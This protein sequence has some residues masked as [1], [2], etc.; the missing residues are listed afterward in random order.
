[1][2]MFLKKTYEL[3]ALKASLRVEGRE[4]QLLLELESNEGGVPNIRSQWKVPARAVGVPQRLERREMPFFALPNAIVDG[5]QSELSQLEL[6]WMHPL[7]L[8]LVKPYGYLG[9]M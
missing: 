3:L 9:V 4:P 6:P 5:V 2:A 8:H 7:W 1:M